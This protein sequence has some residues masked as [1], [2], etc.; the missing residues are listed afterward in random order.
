MWEIADKLPTAYHCVLYLSRITQM[1]SAVSMY[2]RSYVKRLIQ[3]LNGIYR[4][5]YD[6]Y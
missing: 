1:Q 5:C 3:K 4:G 6:G 2:E